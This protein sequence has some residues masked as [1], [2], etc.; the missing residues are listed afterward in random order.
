MA[1]SNTRLEEIRFELKELSKEEKLIR[2][3]DEYLDY[4]T[5]IRSIYDAFLEVGFTEEQTWDA[6]MTLLKK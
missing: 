1:L 5:R 4:T 6:I 2:E 3:H